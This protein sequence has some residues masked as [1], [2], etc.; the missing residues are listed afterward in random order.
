[1]SDKTK[2]LI[3]DDNEGTCDGIA[4]LLRMQYGD[5]IEIVGFAENGAVA[6]ERAQ[7]LNP[8]IVLMDINMPIMNG[9]EATEQIIRSAPQTKIIMVTVQGSTEYLQK[10]FRCN[11]SDYVTKPINPS[12]LYEAIDRYLISP[13][14]DTPPPAITTTPPPPA[15]AAGH[16]IGIVGFKGGAGKTT[17]A[18]N[19][20]IGLAKADKRVVLVD[21]DILFGDAGISLN[22]TGKNTILD[23]ARMATDP[24]DIDPEVADVILASHES[25]LR[26]LLAPTDPGDVQA[27]SSTVMGHL[28]D[29]LKRHFDYVIVDTSRNV[30]D[31]LLATIQSADHLI[32]VTTAAMSAIKD[33]RFMFSEL[34]GVGAMKK[35][36]LAL[37]QVDQRNRITPEQIANHLKMPIAVQIPYDPN[38]VNALNYGVGLVTLDPLR[39]ASAGPLRDMVK[40]ILRQTAKAKAEAAVAQQARKGVLV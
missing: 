29:F 4:Q 23:L 11:A 17:L 33:T 9:I 31:V 40:L 20:G 28:L 13:A 32:V 35:A 26:L 8:H 27:V 1:M 3:V 6:V 14:P 5:D 36:I 39:A 30:D 7:T 15:V 21:G 22:V 12:D 34:G 25:G 38:A 37:N 18:V 24:D 19:L 2:L 10:A 16:I